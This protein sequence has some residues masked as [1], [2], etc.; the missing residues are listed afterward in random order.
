MAHIALYRKWR[1]RTFD[2]VVDQQHIV[3]TLKHMVYTETIAHAYLFCG[4]RGTGKT[5]LAKILANAINCLNPH[6]G[7]PCGECEIC[8]SVQDGSL[9][10][11]MEIDAASNNSVDNIRRIT[12]EVLF[13][14]TLTK[15]K[16][17][18]IDEVHMLSSGAFNALLKTLEEPPAHAVFILATTEA[19]RIPATITSR[20]QR[21]DFR[22][23]SQTAMVERLREIAVT[24]GIDIDDSALL[25]I[26][27]QSDGALRDAISLIDQCHTGIDG[28][29]DR[30][31]VRNLIGVV[32]LSFIGNLVAAVQNVNTE[33]ILQQIETVVRE[34]K[35]TM[36]F[37]AD[38]IQYYR[39]LM[40]CKVSQQPEHLVDGTSTELKQ[41]ISL[42]K[43]YEQ[44]EI[45]A[46]IKQLSKLLSDLRWVSNPRILLEVNLLSLAGTIRGKAS[47]QSTEPMLMA[48][49]TQGGVVQKTQ[50][51]PSAAQSPDQPQK[52]SVV[53]QTTQPQKTPVAEQ[54]PQ[55]Q[56]TPVAEQM[57]QPQKASIAEQTLQP[58]KP[59]FPQTREHTATET[60]AAS[61]QTL[62]PQ[63]SQVQQPQVMSAQK[64]LDRNTPPTPEA[65][66]SSQP[67]VGYDEPVD[68][69]SPLWINT[70][71]ILKNN[72]T[73]IYCFA[74]AALVSGTGKEITLRFN[75][76]AQQNY[77]IL[78]EQ[79][80]NRPL[81]EALRRA[82][83]GHAV[84]VQIVAKDV[85]NQQ[86]SEK[87]APGT[88]WQA[89]LQANLAA[90]GLEI[91][92]EDT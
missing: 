6:A 15:Y 36:R 7:N 32:D 49:P 62:T 63:D 47:V 53:E 35:D 39:D 72:D 85:P 60:H 25:E 3:K 75:S 26:A 83:N 91:E 54:M 45:V 92:R 22:R 74:V 42:A 20:C 64:D 43:I 79:R 56:K 9:M 21:F 2:D 46:I 67:L 17:Y 4:T 5:T 11:I 24:E 86:N 16:V 58:Q 34:G 77:S 55:P 51:M 71:E 30:Q 18:I 80:G 13:L 70:L 8:R 28:H 29:I 66:R 89:E 78:T 41:M 38:I 10:D 65:N 59:L 69:H 73:F 1:P 84:A 12:D 40:V 48:E 37:T 76:A 19:H 90:I 88:E 87:G 61:Q 57:P 52:A 14:P 82:N 44:K 81:K 23:I 50:R 27:R 33:G 31:A 68:G